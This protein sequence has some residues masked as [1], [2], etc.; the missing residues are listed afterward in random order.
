[1]SFHYFSTNRD[2]SLRDL[3]KAHK[4]QEEVFIMME[5]LILAVSHMHSLG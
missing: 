1:M 2:M 3:I 5:H 4:G